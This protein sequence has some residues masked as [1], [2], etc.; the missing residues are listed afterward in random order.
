[1]VQVKY[2]S[3]N[4]SIHLGFPAADWANPR[5]LEATGPLHPCLHFRSDDVPCMNLK[6]T[7]CGI[8]VLGCV[9]ALTPSEGDRKDGSPV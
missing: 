6:E 7:S 2:I 1:M 4:S 3:Q 9:I 8:S 5:D